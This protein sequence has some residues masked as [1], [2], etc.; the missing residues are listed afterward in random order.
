MT[1]SADQESRARGAGSGCFR[2]WR[3]HDFH[4]LENRRPGNPGLQ[5]SE[6]A[7]D[8]GWSEMADCPRCEQELRGPVSGRGLFRNQRNLFDQ[9]EI[10]ILFQDESVPLSL[11]ASLN[12]RRVLT[13]FRVDFFQDLFA[14]DHFAERS[15]AH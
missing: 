13:V 3:S 9:I 6:P 12:L 2:G 7:N 4:S 10:G 14:L 1:E 11:E 5:K 8:S 15:E